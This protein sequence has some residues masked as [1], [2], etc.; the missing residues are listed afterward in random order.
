M[1]TLHITELTWRSAKSIEYSC[2][3]TSH[4]LY[5]LI[6]STK[7]NICSL[8]I[9]A[10]SLHVITL[11]LFISVPPLIQFPL[12]QNIVLQELF[13][14]NSRINPLI[15]CHK[16]NNSLSTFFSFGIL[17]HSLVQSYEICK[18]EICEDLLQLNIWKGSDDT[19]FR[20]L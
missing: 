1:K 6:T 7:P 15:S 10:Y 19:F 5:L 18:S 14:L 8:N 13:E 17:E 11:L 3:K 4:I 20:S 9:P 16:L 12:P 2:Q